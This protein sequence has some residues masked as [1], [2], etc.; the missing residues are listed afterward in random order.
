MDF[1]QLRT[2]RHVAAHGSITAAARALS[3]SQSAASRQLSALEASVGAH[4]FDRDRPRHERCRLPLA[5]SGP[6]VAW[7]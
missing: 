2:F 7:I 3:Y 1:S 4:L 5:G 6:P